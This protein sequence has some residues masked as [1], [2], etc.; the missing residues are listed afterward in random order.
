MHLLLTRPAIEAKAS[1]ARLEALGHAVTL[2]PMLEIVVDSRVGIDPA[3]LAAIAV[4]SP[5][6]VRGKSVV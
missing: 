6:G 1:A 5:R 4:T 3:G 2:A